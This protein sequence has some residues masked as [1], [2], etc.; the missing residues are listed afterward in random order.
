[1]PAYCHDT[2]LA[3]SPCLVLLSSE[4]KRKAVPALTEKQQQVA[5]ESTKCFTEHG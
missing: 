2:P 4:D 3:F 1:M 5:K